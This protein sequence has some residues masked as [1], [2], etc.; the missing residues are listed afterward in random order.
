MLRIAVELLEKRGKNVKVKNFKGALS[1]FTL[2]GHCTWDFSFQTSL[3]LCVCVCVCV[4]ARAR[5]CVF[6]FQTFQNL[7]LEG[8][9]LPD[10]DA[11]MECIIRMVVVADEDHIVDQHFEPEE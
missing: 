8:G 9:S 11:G 3:F 6:S 2:E 7:C 10:F 4:C 1:I 5:A